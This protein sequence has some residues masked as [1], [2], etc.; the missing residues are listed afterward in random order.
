MKY[1]I[2]GVSG[3]PDSM[4]LLD[5][6]RQKKIPLV[7]V[8]I[9]YKK[10]ETSHYDEWVV[11]SYC[12]KYKIPCVIYDDFT[13]TSG[14]FQSLARTYRFEKFKEV[15]EGYQAKKLYL[16]H[17]QDDFLETALFQLVTHRNP[18][19]L[20]I[21]RQTRIKD[22][23]VVRPLLGKTKEELLQY[24]KQNL[25]PFALDESNNQPIYTRN[26]IRQILKTMPNK[27]KNLILEY[28]KVYRTRQRIRNNE[29]KS[30]LRKNKFPILI[31][32]YQKQDTSFRIQLLK[33]CIPFELSFNHIK[34]IDRLIQLAETKTILIKNDYYLCVKDESFYFEQD[35]PPFSPILLTEVRYLKEK[36]FEIKGQGKKI[37]GVTLSLKDFPIIIR[38]AK[39]EDQIQMR[40]GVK[41]INRFFIDRK[42]DRLKRNH[43]PVIENNQG[44]IIFVSGLGCDVDHYS[45]KPTL[46]L[47]KF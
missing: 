25:V 23:N 12:Q 14:N 28:S 1:S 3:G 34:E 45:E 38:P 27:D 13:Y 44:K 39:T 20:G 26:Q 22:M 4:A 9:N 30:F 37:E 41:K 15:Y 43:W 47:V 36:T 18:Q 11:S 16:A 2:I 8:H 32:Y 7:V 5:M 29:I 42:I 40:F 46:F 6:L 33:Y 24:C 35:T 21:A 31:N 19:T 10:R 17:H